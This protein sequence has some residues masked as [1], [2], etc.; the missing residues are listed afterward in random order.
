MEPTHFFTV[1]LCSVVL[2]KLLKWLLTPELPL[3]PGPKGYPIIGNLLRMPSQTPWRTFSEWS[4]VYG[5]SCIVTLQNDGLLSEFRRCHILRSTWST[6]R[7][8]KFCESCLRSA[9]KTIGHLLRQTRLD[10]FEIVRIFLLGPHK[11]LKTLEYMPIEYFGT[12]TW[13]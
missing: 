8:L 5:S 7:G 1:F 9:R 13:A 6:N 11:L 4:K 2:L 12:G 3:P 10:C